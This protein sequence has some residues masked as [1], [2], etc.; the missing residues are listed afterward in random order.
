MR[1]IF[2]FI[3][4]LFVSLLAGGQ[5]KPAQPPKP[6]ASPQ[7]QA[8]A[9]NAQQSMDAA[10]QAKLNQTA[11]ATINWEKS[12]T[13]SAKAEVQLLRKDQV[14]GKAA[15]QYRLKITGAPHNKLY[16]FIA[17]SIT[18]AEPATVMEGLAI[19]ADGTVGCPPNSTR[20][21]AQRFKGSELKLTYTPAIGEIYR[22][23]L[24]SEDHQTRIFFIINPA[25][26]VEHDRACSLEVE[27]LSPRFELA[28]I[29]GRGFVPGE[30]LAFH[31]QS[32]QEVHDSQPKVD[33]SGEFWAVLTPFI[34]GRTMGTEE[35]TVRAKSCAPNLSFEWGSE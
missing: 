28:L 5:A 2:V 3:L 1:Q 25:P 32:Y 24:I 9:Q 29:H 4:L 26:M 7:A 34:K 19:A 15:M 23:A 6:Q 16:S 18:M 33:P 27:R 10:I 21:C 35:V 11:T 30:Q 17:W 20:S 8:P 13:Q 14:N 22:H 31:T 12:T